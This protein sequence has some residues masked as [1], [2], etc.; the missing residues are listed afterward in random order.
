MGGKFP[1]GKFNNGEG[2]YNVTVDTIASVR[3]MN[4]WPTPVVF[5][6]FEIGSKIFTGARLKDAPES[7]VRTAFQYYTG[8]KNRES[9]D[10]TAALYAVRGA[11][12][13]WT[14]SEP[15]LALMHAR[16]HHGYNEWIANSRG[17]HRY[18]IE[19]MPP[20]DVAKVV[21]DLMLEP[22]RR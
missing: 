9:W 12:D 3:A 8:L 17:Q 1:D 2:E 11:R 6:G 13:Y 7:P 19:K 18:L 14:L 4:D 16:V 21:E 5:S 15:G 10:E 20:Q 22:P